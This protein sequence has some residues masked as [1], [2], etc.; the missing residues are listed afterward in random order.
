VFKKK[1]THCTCT[2]CATAQRL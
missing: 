1:Q 2:L